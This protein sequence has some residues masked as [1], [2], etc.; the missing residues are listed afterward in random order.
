MKTGSFRTHRDGPGRIS[1]A[2]WAPRGYPAGFRVYKA[3]APGA[4]SRA[5]TGGW[6]DPATFAA[7]YAAQLAALDPQATYDALVALAA[8][9]EP[10]LLCWELAGEP[11]HRRTVAAWFRDTLGL[12][13][14]ELAL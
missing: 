6:V 2:R 1:I 8:P 7:G 4:W 9:H 12:E 14:A 5:A 3:L 13:V 11:C 10:V